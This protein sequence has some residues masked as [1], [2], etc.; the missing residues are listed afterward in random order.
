MKKRD[1]LFIPKKGSLSL[2][3]NAIVVLV[4]AITML[5]LGLGFTKGM[6]SKFSSK[7][8]VPEPDIPATA[9]DP[10]VLGIGDQLNLQRN[11]EAIFSANVY[12]DGWASTATIAGTI[13]CSNT[14]STLTA[15]SAP[16]TVPPGEDRNFKFI[17]PQTSTSAAGTDICTLSFSDGT[18]PV[19]KQITIK[20]Q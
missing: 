20:V 5:G 4:L 6:F 8:E 7:L 18:L 13:V 10:I 16:Q 1:S 17:I 3:I 9:Q 14:L 15:N 11:K 2:S 19:T 12:N